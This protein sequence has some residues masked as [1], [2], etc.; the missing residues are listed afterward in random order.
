MPIILRLAQ[1]MN[2][3]ELYA[4]D[5]AAELLFGIAERRVQNI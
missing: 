5:P 2:G 3:C 1:R 4:S